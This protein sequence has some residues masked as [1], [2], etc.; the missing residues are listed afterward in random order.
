ML[1]Y[2]RGLARSQAVWPP[3]ASDVRGW[4]IIAYP[5]SALGTAPGNAQAFQIVLSAKLDYEYAPLIMIR[6][7]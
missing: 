4:L 5:M 3:A 6:L 7:D 1:A 2:I